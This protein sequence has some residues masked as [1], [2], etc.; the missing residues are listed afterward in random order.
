MK[1]YSLHKDV[2]AYRLILQ[3]TAPPNLNPF[4]LVQG[5]VLRLTLTEPERAGLLRRKWVLCTPTVPET[6]A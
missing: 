5:R 4:L 1:I 6:K 3:Q 2:S